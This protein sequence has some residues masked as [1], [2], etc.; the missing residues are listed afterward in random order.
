[1]DIENN[2]FAIGGIVWILEII[3]WIL[4]GIGTF[5]WIGVDSFWSAIIW[6]IVWHIASTISYIILFAIVIGIASKLK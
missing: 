4:I 1:M 2:G 5:N 3:V 6:L